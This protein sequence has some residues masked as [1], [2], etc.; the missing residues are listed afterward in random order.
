LETALRV[1]NGHGAGRRR[2]GSHTIQI[3]GNGSDQEKKPNRVGKPV[4]LIV[5]IHLRSVLEASTPCKCQ[6]A[7]LPILEAVVAAGAGRAKEV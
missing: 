4:S 1:Q 6:L 3:L 2:W 5:S 7:D